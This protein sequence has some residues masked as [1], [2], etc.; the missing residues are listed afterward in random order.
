MRPSES[1]ARSLGTRSDGLRQVK[2]PNVAIGMKLKCMTPYGM[3]GLERARFILG[4][5]P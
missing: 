1:S 5:T 3:L 4:P 2:I